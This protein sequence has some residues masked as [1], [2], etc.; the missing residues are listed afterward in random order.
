M[1]FFIAV[2]F[3]ALGLRMPIAEAA[4]Q[5]WPALVLTGFVLGGKFLIISLSL[6]RLRF[7]ERT[8]FLAALNLTQISE[9]SFILAASA[10]ATGWVGPEML[11][12]VG[13][14][15]LTTIALSSSAIVFQEPLYVAAL[16]RGWLRFLRAPKHDPERP[17]GHG[18]HGH[19][20]VV[21]MNTLGR[22][23]VRR[24]HDR[25]EKVLAIDT[26]PR[27]LAGLPCETS[28]GN[29]EYLSVL[30]DAGLKE[31]RLLV[32]AL[33]IEPANDLLA[34]RCRQ[35]DIPAAIQVVDL[36]VVDNLLEMDVK[37][38]MIPKIDGMKLQNRILQED[39]F[40]EG[41]ATQ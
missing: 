36:S 13:L 29:V 3:V 28:L 19:I 5:W 11:S 14:V 33:R 10:M 12:L 38:L 1:N 2:F 25:G 35:F 30:E 17:H 16:K 9:F 34:Y 6:A 18:R 8:A 15:G 41:A 27:K 23:I 31:A 40:L 20:I 26:D 4:A 24:L 22:D 21:G 37:Y 39:G 7:S 32:S